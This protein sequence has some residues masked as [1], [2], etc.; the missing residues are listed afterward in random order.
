MR[1]LFY[2]FIG[3]LFSQAAIAN[4]KP[5]DWVR[6]TQSA[7]STAKEASA[8]IPYRE[9]Q[10]AQLKA[11]FKNIADLVELVETDQKQR[12]KIVDYFKKANVASLCESLVMPKSSWE[13][14]LRGC[15]RNSFFV[16]A[17]EIQRYPS[18]LASLGKV[19][20]SINSCAGFSEESQGK[21]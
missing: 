11:Y 10:Q 20:P 17:E 5:Q 4:V 8:N 7:L 6:N 21:Q 18:L 13:P 19:I 16:C 12:K 15:T 9:A 14:I 2:I 1:S 3:L